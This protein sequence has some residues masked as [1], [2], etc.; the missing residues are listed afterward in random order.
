MIKWNHRTC[1]VIGNQQPNSPIIVSAARHSAIPH[2]NIQ[3]FIRINPELISQDLA[4][5][6][7]FTHVF[8][9]H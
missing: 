1:I 4:I 7:T 8:I 6:N 9:Q 5:A 3:F 2:T